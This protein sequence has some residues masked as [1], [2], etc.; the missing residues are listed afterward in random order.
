MMFDVE[1]GAVIVCVGCLVCVCARV[2]VGE[3]E[4]AGRRRRRRHRWA[5]EVTLCAVLG[6]AP[7]S[8]GSATPPGSS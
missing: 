7:T 8:G 5:V 2:R 3:V 1:R 6:E 4:S